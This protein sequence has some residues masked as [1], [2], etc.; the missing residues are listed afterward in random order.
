MRTKERIRKLFNKVELSVSSYDTAWVAMV[1]SPGCPKSPCFPECVKWLMDNQL[2]NGSWGLYPLL[3]KDT[4]SST[5]ASIVALKK[6]NVGQHQINKGLSFIESNLS[7]ATDKKQP[8]PFGFEIIFPHMLE[9][10][11]DLNVKL[12]LNEKELSL[13]LDDRRLELTSA[14]RNSKETMGYLA[15]I[16]EGLGRDYDRNMVMKYQMKNGSILNSPSA[17]AAALID[18]QNV[19]CL[20]YL[21]SLLGKFGNAVPT[22]Y[23]LDIYLRL[24]MVDQLQ[25]LGIS[26]HFMDEIQTV[27]D[28]SYTNW[29]Q[30]DEQIFTSVGTCALAFRVLRTNGYQISSDPLAEITKKG[31]NM[32]PH[33][34]PAFEVDI[35]AA[36]EAYR[37]SQIIYQHESAFG[38][39]NLLSADFVKRNISTTLSKHLHKQVDD[40]F[41]F[42][43][44]A[45]LE[46]VSTR[47]NIQNYNVADDTRILKT[48]YRSSNISNED[49][50]RLA[51]KDFNAS[52]LIYRKE[53]KDL[54]RWLVENKLDK[55]KS[56]QRMDYCYFSGASVISSPELSDAR[57]TW[58]K[59]SYLVTLVDDFFDVDGYMDELVNL[60]QC[61]EKWNVNVETDCCCEEV[62]IL[63]LALKDVVS[64]IGDAAFKWQARDVTS[65]VIQCWLKLLNSMLTEA[66][67]ARYNVVPTMNEYIETS[68]V[69]FT[70]CT[71]VLPALY[72]IGPKLSEDVVHSS[73]YNTL[74]EIMS[75]HGRLINDIRSF[76]R[77]LKDD[78][79]NAV[80]LHNNYGKNGIEE[81]EI[82][83]EIK[84]MINELEKKLMRLVLE[85][86][87]SVVPKACKD[88]FWKMCCLDIFFYATGDGFTENYLLDTV[89]EVIHEP[90]FML[91][92]IPNE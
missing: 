54:K 11:K 18:H 87:E 36:L 49:Y 35:H 67:W 83:E 33:K 8:S 60:I 90:V 52:Q 82:V 24:Y 57:I 84:T 66:K 4:L 55:I 70:L 62:H 13:M 53:L 25:R 31:S 63:F 41:K 72:F 86:K 77:E 59:S 17:S 32:S 39:L 46:R 50:I 22:V 12:P 40:A 20:D 79:L 75:I 27:L 30:R 34:D 1:P 10:A 48:A 16:S 45:S 26:R 51:E 76:K 47:R 81:E 78:K 89:K 92:N 58:A 14:K 19:R 38:E 73:E 68:C 29:M 74:Y 3:L 37:A 69:S 80:T 61:V 65:H 5:L 88:V 91:K 21:T 28:E 85:S 7:L 6:W 42:P 44:Y 43:L 64:W 23:P 71:F 2:S 15:Y 9:Y 56:R